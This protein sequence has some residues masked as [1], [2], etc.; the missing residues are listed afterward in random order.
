MANDA[1]G[2]IFERFA[3]AGPLLVR[4]MAFG[5]SRT[6]FAAF[7]VMLNPAIER[8]PLLTARQ[9]PPVRVLPEEFV[10][11]FCE[12]TTAPFA[13]WM[14]P[15]FVQ[16]IDGGVLNLRPVPIPKVPPAT[17]ADNVPRLT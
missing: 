9:V 17:S 2:R 5:P 16:D 4:K 8:I 7:V 11:E 10:G 14:V 12:D 13:A 15:L 1:L 6:M 3:S